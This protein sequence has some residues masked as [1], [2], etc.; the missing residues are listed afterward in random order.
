[1]ENKENNKTTK[2]FDVKATN[3][4]SDILQKHALLIDVSIC[5]W[6]NNRASKTGTK[7]LE[8]AFNIENGYNQKKK[9][10]AYKSAINPEHLRD[11]DKICNAFRT[12]IYHVTLPYDNTGKRLLPAKLFD[13]VNN[14]IRMFKDDFQN[15]KDRIIE[16]FETWKQE[17]SLDLNSL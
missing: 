15:E 7:A 14:Q 5:K 8:K 16:N 6:N 17:A 11:M 2:K 10:R 1:M 9:V 12:Y 13:K 4:N 3:I